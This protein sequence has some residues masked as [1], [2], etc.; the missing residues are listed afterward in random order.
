MASRPRVLMLLDR[1]T[2]G[3]GGAEVFTVGLSKALRDQ[4]FD[5][6]ICTTRGAVGF[7]VEEVEAS[8][9]PHVVLGR[10]GRFDMAPFVRLRRYLRAERIDVLHSHMF[11]SNL[12]GSVIGKVARVPV[13]VAHEHTWS[14][15][16]QPIRKF[17]DGELIG[18]LTDAFVTVSNA[19]RERM[20][21]LEGVNPEK[22]VVIP[23]AYVPRTSEP[24]RTTSVREELGIPD[25]APVVGTIVTMRREKALDVLVDAVAELRERAPNVHMIVV[26]SGVG[27][28]E[29]QAYS[30]ERGLGDVGHWVGFRTDIGAL[31]HAFDV[32]VL[33]SDWEGSPLFVLESMAHGTAV[34]CTGVGGLP[35]V[36]EDGVSG[37]LVPPRDPSALADALAKVIGDPRLRA[38]LAAAAT[39]RLPEFSMD[40][41]AARFGGLYEGLLRRG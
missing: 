16:G 25:D 9:I 30:E 17:L 31:I 26:G 7:L 35:D 4:G 3:G 2:T 34:V 18:R 14:Y 40:R 6:R 20:I 27:R 10:R 8:G 11:G 41:I 21:G 39:E 22:V 1:F 36:I 37:L 29:W 13:L 33:S 28:E 19:N 38:R 15:E 12:W 32:G 23:T 5:V 24:E